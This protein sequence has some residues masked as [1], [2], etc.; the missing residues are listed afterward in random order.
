M[1][2]WRKILGAASAVAMGGTALVAAPTV[3][4]QEAELG[5]TRIA[6]Y[7][8]YEN[9]ADPSAETVAEIVA[10]SR[11]EMTLAYT[12]GEGGTVGFVDISDPSAPA[13][14]GTVDVGGEPTSVAFK[15]DYA[16]VAV[17]TSDSF[18]EPSGKLVVV[19]APIGGEA[20]SIVTEIPLIGQPDS[21]A[22]SP[23]GGYAAIVIENERDEDLG[24][25]A[26]PQLPGGAMQVLRLGY[27]PL[28]WADTIR[29][30]DFAGLPEQF[31]DDPEPEYVDIN[32]R[33]QAVVSFQEQPRRRDQGVERE[34][35]LEFQRWLGRPGPGRC[36]RGRHH[37]PHGVARRRAP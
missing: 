34:A 10:V 2:M 17:N 25:G 28:G 20:A 27:N 4:A 13:G 37:L 6:S 31:G 12:D 26:P 7:S 35:D 32:S 36:D 15:H 33:N 22:V 30:F 9:N 24:D 21:I 8:V 5:F 19:S 18:T 1:T 14:L 11:D 23:A 3:A 29:T 16:L